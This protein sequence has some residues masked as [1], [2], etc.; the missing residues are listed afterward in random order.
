MAYGLHGFITPAS[1]TTIARSS[2]AVTTRFR[3]TNAS[4]TAIPASLA[5]ALAEARDTRATLT[6]PGI[7][8]VTATCTWSASQQDLTC[9]VRIPPGA[10]TGSSQ[11][12]TLTATEDLGDGFLTVPAV[13]G[14]TD[15]EVIHFK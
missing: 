5:K 1:G 7:K 13:H 3:L 4:G 2:K 10:R 12:Y 9:A 14:T 11:K 6:G 8:A 15:P